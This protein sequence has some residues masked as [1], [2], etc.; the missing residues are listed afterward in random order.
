MAVLKPIPLLSFDKDLLSYWGKIWLGSVDSNGGTKKPDCFDK[1]QGMDFGKAI[2]P[3][4]AQT[5]ATMLGDIPVVSPMSRNKLLPPQD[6]CV[7]IGDTRL[8]GGI[9]TQNYDIM[10]RP[11]G[12]RIAYDS[13]TLND[14]GSIG[15]N[16]HNMIN[17]LASEATTVH[18]RFPYALALF[19]VLIPKDIFVGKQTG[20]IIQTLE[21]LNGRVNIREEDYRAESIALVIW[22][23][24]TGEVDGDLPD[25]H[26]SLR[27]E[28]YAERIE[29]MYCNRYAGL[30]PHTA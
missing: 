5:F 11:D 6:D 22:D 17:D 4:V 14:R 16:W 2:D 18:T 10:Y 7:E 23:P 8:V 15:K 20:E 25:A 26:S 12:V 28:K 19:L 1:K 3:I 13:K 29:R 27:L 30:P 21:R 9:R 24:H